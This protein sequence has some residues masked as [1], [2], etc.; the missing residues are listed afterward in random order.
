VATASATFTDAGADDGPFTCTVDYGD[1]GGAQAATVAGDTCTGPP[2][3][4]ADDGPYTVEVAVTDKDGGTG[5]ATASHGV[6]NVAPE[7]TAT[8]NSAE[9]CGDTPEGGLVEVSADFSDPG[10]D[11]AVAGTLEDFTDS[12]IDWGDGTVEPAGVDETPGSAGT[13]TTGTVS[14]SHVYAG[15]GI[16]TVSITV[17]DDDGGTDAVELVALV[18]GAGLDGGELQVVGTDWK[19]VIQVQ[20]KG[21]AVEVKAGFLGTPGKAAFPA[22]DV[23]S[24]RVVAC[25]GDDQVLVNHDVGV[26]AR[27]EGGGDRDHLRAGGGPAV[28]EGGDGD[29]VVHGGP[30]ADVLLGGAGD[31]ALFGRAGEDLIEGGDGDDQLHGNEGDDGLDGGAGFDLCHGTPGADVIVNCEL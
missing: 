12:T 17:A 8:T 19:D 28:L 26:P 2:H 6:D 24:L 30:A 25:D 4:Y 7:I 5:S 1:G 11:S 29:D 14:G 3:H 18:T 13:P 27:L 15:G 9:G 31:D 22:G 16:F 20:A 23:T 10:F 21:D